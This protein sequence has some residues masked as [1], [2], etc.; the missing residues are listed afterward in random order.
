MGE[1]LEFFKLLQILVGKVENSQADKDTDDGRVQRI[2]IKKEKISSIKQ[3][4]DSSPHEHEPDDDGQIM[5]EIRDKV[6]FF[7]HSR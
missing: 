5:G 1:Q 6:S 2:A 3:M 4:P 7:H